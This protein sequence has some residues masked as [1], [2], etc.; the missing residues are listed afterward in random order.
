MILYH[1]NYYKENYYYYSM[2]EGELGDEEIKN[3]FKKL[4]PVPP[5]QDGSCTH[6]EWMG[7]GHGSGIGEWKCK[8]QEERYGDLLHGGGS[9][10]LDYKPCDASNYETCTVYLNHQEE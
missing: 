8:L 10:N 1:I 5:H 2:D 7:F 3:I 9:E 6:I 4:H